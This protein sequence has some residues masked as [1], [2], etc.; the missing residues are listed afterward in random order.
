MFETFST[1]F[2]HQLKVPQHWRASPEASHPQLQARVQ[3]Q[4]QDEMHVLHQI[5]RPP[6]QPA[7]RNIFRSDRCDC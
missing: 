6:H 7:G 5:H 3:A 4:R 1:G 2:H